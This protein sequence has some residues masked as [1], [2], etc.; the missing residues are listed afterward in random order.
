M[1]EDVVNRAR[2]LIEE[3]NEEELGLLM[4]INHG[5]FFF[6]RNFAGGR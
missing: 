1:I 6:R 5:C 4:Y 3:N 2:N